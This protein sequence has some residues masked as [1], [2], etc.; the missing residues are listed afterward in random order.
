MLFT[1]LPVCLEQTLGFVL[2]TLTFCASSKACLYQFENKKKK[3]MTLALEITP[4]KK[5]IRSN[6]TTISFNFAC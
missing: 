1:S 6:P 5:A 4:I 2:S 3:I